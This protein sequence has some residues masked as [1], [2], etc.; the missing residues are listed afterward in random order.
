[1]LPPPHPLLLSWCHDTHR[2]DKSD[3]IGVCN[4][5]TADG[6]INPVVFVPRSCG[7]VPVSRMVFGSN[8]V[9]GAASLRSASGRTGSRHKPG[10]G[11][12]RSRFGLPVP[13]N[14]NRKTCRSMSRRSARRP[15][16]KA[17]VVHGRPVTDEIGH[18]KELVATFRL[19]KQRR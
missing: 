9:I 12:R 6:V 15:S 14:L 18:Q 13:G 11:A 8:S 4:A 10:F 7:R 5:H 1:M 19:E 16:G 2:K 3:R 17:V